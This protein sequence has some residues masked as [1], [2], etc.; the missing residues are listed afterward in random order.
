[1]A[2]MMTCTLLPFNSFGESIEDLSEPKIENITEDVKEVEAPVPSEDGVEPEEITTQA[3]SGEI[4]KELKEELLPAA[5]NE[6]SQDLPFEITTYGAINTNGQFVD[7]TNAQGSYPKKLEGYDNIIVAQRPIIQKRGK[8]KEKEVM[9]GYLLSP[10]AEIAIESNVSDVK[11][12][13]TRGDPTEKGR[14]FKIIR[15]YDDEL[16]HTYGNCY[17]TI[18]INDNGAIK[19]YYLIYGTLNQ[20]QM[21]SGS[22]IGFYD[23]S[24]EEQMLQFK[25]KELEIS[26][27]HSQIREITVP[28][29][30]KT[31]GIQV[32]STTP[33]KDNPLEQYA[34]YEDALSD[35]RVSLNGELIGYFDTSSSKRSSNRMS[36]EFSLK[37]GLNVLEVRCNASL[38]S[39]SA[40]KNF[41]IGETIN[42]GVYVNWRDGLQFKSYVFLFHWEG[43]EVPP[44]HGT[45]TSLDY[46]DAT[47]VSMVK[48]ATLYKTKLNI[49]ENTHQITLP[50]VMPSSE[51]SANNYKE[52]KDALLYVGIRTK[53]PGAT[54]TIKIP[55]GSYLMGNLDSQYDIIFKKRI[56][57]FNPIYI[58]ELDGT[59]IESFQVEI[60]AADGKTKTIH[61][62]KLVHA[63]DST[64]ISDFI[65]AGAD[66]EPGVAF[67]GKKNNYKFIPKND[68][69]EIA[70]S[71]KLPIGSSMAIGEKNVEVAANGSFH[72]SMV[73]PKYSV[74]LEVT[75]P[76]GVTKQDYFFLRM[77]E[78]KT[79]PYFGIEPSTKELAEQ[80]LHGY[81]RVKEEERKEGISNFAASYWAVFMASSTGESMDGGRVFDVTKHTYNQTTDYAAVILQLVLQ[82][83]NPYNFKG[84]NYVQEMIDNGGGPFACNIWYVMAAKAVGIDCSQFV[85]ELKTNAVSPTYDPDMR[86]WC[87]A[88]LHGIVEDEDMAYYADKLQERLIRKGQFAGQFYYQKGGTPN[89]NTMGCIISALATAGVDP[90]KHFAVTDAETLYTPLTTT[91]DRHMNA[92]GLFSYSAN[93][94]RSVGLWKDIIIAMG[95]LING[96]SVWDRCALTR[97]KFDQLV[98]KAEGMKNGTEQQ[99]QTLQTAISNAKEEAK[100]VETGKIIGLGKVYYDLYEAMAA[101]DTSMTAKV[102]Y[103]MPYVEFQEMIKAFPNDETLTLEDKI[104]VK[105]CIDF[106]EKWKKPF[107]DYWESFVGEQTLEKYGN[108]RRVILRLE[109]TEKTAEVFSKMLSLPDADVITLQDKDKVEAV[110]KA[111]NLLNAEQKALL[112]WAGS[113]V[114]DRYNDAKDMIDKLSS[115]GGSNPGEKQIKV[116]FTLLG[117]PKHGESG[118]KYVYEKNPNDFEEWI[119]KTKY[120]YNGDSVTVYKVFMRGLQEYGLDQEG[121]KG[122]Y[123]KKIKGPDGWL[124]EFD[125]GKNSGWMYTINEKH[126]SGGLLEDKLTNGDR[127]VWHYTD[128]Y[129]QEE[130]SE[131]W[132][133][134]PEET[135][136]EVEVRIDAKAKTD[137]TGKAT[138]TI[139]SK[140][141]KAALDKALEAVKKAEKDGK[142]NVKPQILL[143]VKSDSNASIVETTVPV[144]SMEELAKEEV[145]V[146]VITSIGTIHVE[147]KT[148]KEVQKAAE[149]KEISFQIARIDKN[150]ASAK[151]L[152]EAQKKAVGENLV[153]DVSIL[154]GEKKIKTFGSQKL[155]ILLPYTLKSGE[156]ANQIAAWYLDDQGKLTKLTSKYDEKTKLVT[157]EINHLSCFVVGKDIATD[158]DNGFNDVKKGQWYYDS[159]TYLVEKGIVSGTTKDTFS[160]NANITRAEFTQIL[161]GMAKSQAGASGS[162]ITEKSVKVDANEASKIFSDVKNTDWYAKAVAWAYAN[163]IV[164]GTKMADNSISFMPNAKITR[165]DMAVM[166]QNYIQK[167]EKKTIAE[168][169][170]SISFA[171][172]AKIATYAKDAVSM[173]QKGGI[174]SGIKQEDGS[175]EFAPKANA[176][177]AEAATMIFKYLKK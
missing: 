19:D 7:A 150:S 141:L 106:Y 77:E 32:Y 76:D 148:L 176:T 96:G 60:T 170:Q 18:K 31:M 46:L 48:E 85:E 174:I 78:D 30:A 144:S 171:D 86:S 79:I 99:M 107:G 165:Q 142:K 24:T 82:G 91:R 118:K 15:E 102:K 39:V 156:N 66:L 111:Y 155:S 27:G 73:M 20:G 175:Y 53:D 87:I 90:E 63:D 157:F 21:L 132:P 52:A 4:E 65:I 108:V 105:E 146:L 64:A 127:L 133:N 169:N 168:K 93:E 128:D 80:L 70:F 104:K 154:S 140:D 89:V 51:T 22:E 43:E 69:E 138:V 68:A 3:A 75:A 9:E 139:T 147:N 1:M 125:N 167:A 40:N 34:S 130:G 50:K 162:A 42:S 177:R 83:E 6:Q 33:F 88:A 49:G 122:G 143:N 58:L 61:T 8:K 25:A 55:E 109:G 172:D 137:S 149:G 117:V 56:G 11:Y 95:D 98:V 62:I 67:S 14:S 151:T 112:D 158:G 94:D 23:G 163:D 54:Y 123:V 29:S 74:R 173:M 136:S 71:G 47:L 45:D 159:I 124:G 166:I 28:S 114:M 17:A 110:T 81:R 145:E 161:Y 119:P 38:M 164:K 131:K 57:I 44:L 126:P 101:I 16:D 153:Y 59:P 35:N 129:K 135:N 160:P 100:T 103:G 116:Y 134:K 5:L 72:V 41:Q 97:D 115:G 36:P 92:D 10:S 12:D 121:A 37:K 120:I 84:H 26:K 113:S 13:V 2:V 152:T